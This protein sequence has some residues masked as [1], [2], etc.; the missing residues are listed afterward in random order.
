M[1]TVITKH[2]NRGNAYYRQGE[3]EKAIASYQK[4]IS[5]NPDYAFAHNNLGSTYYKQGKYDLAIASYQTVIG[6]NPNYARAHNSLGIAYYKQGKWDE[7]IAVWKKATSIKPK[8]AD[9]HYNVAF[10]YA[11]KNEKVSSIKSLQ[12]AINLD[13]S[14]I[15]RA[16]ADSDF[17]NIRESPEF[18]QLIK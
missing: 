10:T 8:L 14:L 1:R 18:K 3:Y 9:A 16:K 15:E 2:Y 12:T 6:I 4:A 7:A 13:K 17:D 5:I 11:L